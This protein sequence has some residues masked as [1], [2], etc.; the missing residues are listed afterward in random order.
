MSSVL[1]TRER[2][3]YTRMSMRMSVLIDSGLV[4]STDFWKG[5]R[6]S[7]RC[8]RDTYPESYITKYTLVYEDKHTGGVS[9]DLGEDV[10][11]DH[12]EPDLRNADAVSTS[13]STAF[14]Q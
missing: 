9:M 3:L 7:R 5:F 11:R 13:H 12:A 6:E 2:V 4:G 14:V 8:S 1:D 10:R